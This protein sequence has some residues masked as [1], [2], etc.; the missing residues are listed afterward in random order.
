MFCQVGELTAPPESL[1]LPR[2][3]SI[4]ESEDFLSD[5]ESARAEGLDSICAAAVRDARAEHGAEEFDLC[6]NVC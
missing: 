2:I 1:Q 4:H 3:Q 5:G 6:S